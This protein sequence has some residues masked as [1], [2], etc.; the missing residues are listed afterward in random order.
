MCIFN[1]WMVFNDHTFWVRIYMRKRL[2]TVID[3]DIKQYSQATPFKLR[4][5]LIHSLATAQKIVATSRA[6]HY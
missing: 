2:Y 3:Y 5:D 4:G 1:T 6:V